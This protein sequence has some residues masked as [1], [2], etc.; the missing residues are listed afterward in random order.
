LK[1]SQI[2]KNEKAEMNKIRFVVNYRIVP[3]YIFIV[4]LILIT[5]SILMSIDEIK[6]TPL[7]ITLFI[8]IAAI[9][10]ILLISVPFVRKK[11]IDMEMRRYDLCEIENECERTFNFSNDDFLLS[12]DSNGMTLNDDFF[13]YNHLKISIDTSNYLNRV[14]ISIIF[15]IDENNYCRIPFNGETISM[16]RK[17]NIKLENPEVFEYIICN[18]EDAFVQIYKTGR[19][20]SNEQ[21]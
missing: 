18:K 10:V 3:A 21:T 15:L 12:F 17:F 13:W 4:I 6:Y 14:L 9:T 16:V 19:V 11:E 5:I 2:I 7:A 1:F 8:I 20:H